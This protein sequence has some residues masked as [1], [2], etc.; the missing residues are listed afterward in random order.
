MA[1]RSQLAAELV[2]ARGARSLTRLLPYLPFLNDT[3]RAHVLNELAGQ[4]KWD[5]ATRRTLL[6][7]FPESSGQHRE[8]IFRRLA[9]SKLTDADAQMLEGHLTR[10][11]PG[12][13]E[14]LLS[15]LLSQKN[16][17]ALTSAD[18]LVE[19]ANPLQRM[20][21][22]QLLHDLAEAGRV[23]LACQD[24]A[25]VYRA[26]HPAIGRSERDLLD[27]ILAVRIT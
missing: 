18:R 11:G 21:G 16:T 14:R 4:K 22:L 5:T 6:A 25:E 27:A 8:T 2:E 3:L 26:I 1:D 15:L 10:E 24:R 9:K 13:R 23:P 12:L 19:S 7:L 17:A 20:A